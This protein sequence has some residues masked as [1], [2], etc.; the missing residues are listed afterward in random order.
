MSNAIATF[1]FQS[2]QLRTIKGADGEPWFV[3][4]DVCA[5]LELSNP[6]MV[7]SRL[8]DDERAKFNLGR[9]GEATIINESGLYAVYRLPIIKSSFVD[10]AIKAPVL[11]LAALIARAIFL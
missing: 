5:V 6:S 2:N 11:L 7:A 10:L 8:D 4:A 1:N 3:L 9:Q